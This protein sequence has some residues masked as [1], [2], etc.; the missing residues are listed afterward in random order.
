MNEH[1]EILHGL[2]PNSVI[3]LDSASL[4]EYMR[5]IQ[6]NK[7]N[8]FELD[9]TEMVR[10]EFYHRDANNS[11]NYYSIRFANSGTNVIHELAK[12]LV[13]QGFESIAVPSYTY[14]STFTSL[15]K[16]GLKIIPI[17]IGKDGLMLPC[18]ADLIMP[19]SLSGLD[20]N[21]D[22]YDGYI[23]EDA[24]QSILSLYD[25]RFSS[26]LRSRIFSFD[27]TKPIPSINGM[28]MIVSNTD[29]FRI[30]EQLCKPTALSIKSVC[31]R[32]KHFDIIKAN[33]IILNKYAIDKLNENGFETQVTSDQISEHNAL[34]K[35]I[36]FSEY[37]LEFHFIPEAIKK[38]YPY[39]LTP[40]MNYSLFIGLGEF[41]NNITFNS[42]YTD[43][44]YRYEHKYVSQAFDFR[45]YHGTTFENIDNRINKL[46]KIRESHGN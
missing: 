9:I 14:K 8:A 24:C 18:K 19:V 17:P 10:S 6:E 41:S 39:S 40:S 3:D 20:L 5:M 36:F 16:G 29:K 22:L 21:Y 33:R 37:P 46:I 34:S 35:I 28:G 7:L 30:N 13:Q 42:Q 2:N 23:F 32:L 43:D 12:V 31:N 25:D 45:I 15:L 1:A 38:M 26:N 11:N 4:P 27:Q 44:M